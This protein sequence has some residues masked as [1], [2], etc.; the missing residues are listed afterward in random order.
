M[1]SP[2]FSLISIPK[3]L[4]ESKSPKKYP[5]LEHLKNFLT[6]IN[7]RHINFFFDANIPTT[8]IIIRTR[9]T[10]DWLH[11]YYNLSWVSHWWIIYVFAYIFAVKCQDDLHLCLSVEPSESKALIA[12]THIG[13]NFSL[14]FIN[15]KHLFS[16]SRVV[17]Q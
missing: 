12:K 6:E 5:N 8:T 3:L 13:V 15:F 2:C 1:N 17:L 11:M 7:F 14:F 9:K 16:K 10:R 4:S